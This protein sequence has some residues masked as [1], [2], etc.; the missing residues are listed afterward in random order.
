M[1]LEDPFGRDLPSTL[2]RLPIVAL[3]AACQDVRLREAREEPAPP[4]AS[5]AE[6]AAP[7]EDASESD[8]PADG[9]DSPN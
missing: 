2:A 5:H 4:A 1:H 3:V 9:E 6:D 7:P 8:E